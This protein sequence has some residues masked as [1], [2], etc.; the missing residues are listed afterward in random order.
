MNKSK[1]INMSMVSASEMSVSKA[2]NVTQ[3]LD[4]DLKAQHP[5]EDSE[6][7]DHVSIWKY[8]FMNRKLSLLFLTSFILFILGTLSTIFSQYVLLRW[9]EYTHDK[10]PDIFGVSFII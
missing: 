9:I 6:V 3:M 8:F 1:Q 4:D 7:L 2:S 10:E 5:F